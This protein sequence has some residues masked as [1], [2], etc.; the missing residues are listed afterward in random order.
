MLRK[1][2]FAL[3]LISQLS[4]FVL[5]SY[6]VLRESFAGLA[7]QRGFGEGRFGEGTYGGGLTRIQELLVAAGIK[8]GLLPGD[9]TLTITDRKR[10]AACAIA[11]VLLLGLSILFDL[12]L[13]YL[14]RQ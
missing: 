12:W 4:G 10:N 3:W 9:R 1:L 13:R 6:G 7:Q 14:S 11:G 8:T 2:V 5:A